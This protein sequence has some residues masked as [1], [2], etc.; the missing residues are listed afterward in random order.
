MSQDPFDEARSGF[1]R[2]DDLLGRLLIVAPKTLEQRKSKENEGTYDAIMADVVVCDGPVTEEIENVPITLD[3]I[4]FGG[5]VVVNQLKSKIKDGKLVLGRLG[6]QERQSGKKG[7]PA[8]VLNPPTDKDK[9]LARPLAL[10][11][12]EANDPFAGS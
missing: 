6:Q 5:V 4:Q 10:A 8:W 11:Y 2:L 3:N 9:D 1:I 7:Q 12:R